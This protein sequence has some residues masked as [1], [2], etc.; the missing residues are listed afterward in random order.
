M[1]LFAYFFIVNRNAA[2]IEDIDV[3]IESLIGT[4]SSIEESIHDKIV[5]KNEEWKEIY[6]KWMKNLSKCD[7]MKDLYELVIEFND[8]LSAIQVNLN[9]DRLLKMLWKDESLRSRWVAVSIIYSFLFLF[10]LFIVNGSN[11][12]IWFFSR[13]F[14]NF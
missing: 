5:F 3:G 9:E 7:N 6:E 12:N 2:N 13:C 8:F 1:I 4:L 11:S 10:L 14:I